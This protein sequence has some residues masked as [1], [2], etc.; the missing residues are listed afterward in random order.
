MGFDLSIDWREEIPSVDTVV[1]GAASWAVWHYLDYDEYADTVR[2]GFAAAHAFPLAL[3]ALAALLVL[4]TRDTRPVTLPAAHKQKK[5]VTTARA[6]DINVL[7]W[8]AL[9]TVGFGGAAWWVHASVADASLV[10]LVWQASK[11]VL[12]ARFLPVFEVHLLRR[13]PDEPELGCN[14]HLRRPFHVPGFFDWL[15]QLAKELKEAKRELT[16]GG[17]KG[18]RKRR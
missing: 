16:G 12:G 17:K 5:R 18:R 8:Y 2:L 13:R 15:S 3:S 7:L 6:H 9:T 1:A 10:P 14:K 11:A 4:C